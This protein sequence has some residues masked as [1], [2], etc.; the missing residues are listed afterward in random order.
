MLNLFYRNS[1][2]LVL[3]ICL[4]MVA[5]LSSLWVLPRMEDPLSTPRAASVTTIFPGADAERVESLVTE[6]LEEALE[7]IQ[8][9]KEVRSTS[10]AGISFL[11]IELRDDVYEATAPS[12][13]SRIR[14]KLDDAAVLM[15]PGALEPEFDEV[16]VKAYALIVALRW[17]MDSPPS[18][19]ILRRLL[20]Q[21]EDRVSGVAGTEKSELYGD[22]A[23]EIV[24]TLNQQSAV[25]LDLTPEQI[26]RQ[27]QASDAKVSA[28]QMRNDAGDLLLEV[29]GEL[30][31]LTRIGQT[32]IQFGSDGS[33]V[34]LSDIA[35]IEKTIPDPPSSLSLVRNQPAVCLG[36]LVR[37]DARIDSWTHDVM[38]VL[39]QFEAELPTGVK[40]DVIFKQNNYVAQRLSTLMSNLLLG[41]LAV[42]AV[43]F[44][45][46][47]WRSSLIVG[48]ALPLA[49]L[50]V[51]SGLRFL[52]V[53]IHQMSVTG[54]IIALGLLIDNAIVVVDEIA[55]KLKEGYSPA[56]AVTKCVRHLAVPL[57]GSTL[58]TALAFGPI[59]L[60]PGPAGEFVGSI[61]TS[62][63]LAVFSSLL[64]AL[65]VVP[66]FAALGLRVADDQRHA[67]WWREGFSN[68]SL[69]RV[70]TQCLDFVF[71]RPVLGVTLPLV[72]PILGFV[73]A[74]QLPEQFF[75]PADR[76][77]LQVELELPANASIKDTIAV[78]QAIREEALKEES[79]VAM[80][81][82]FGES[83]PVFYYNVIPTRK[84]QPRY[85]QA[86][87]QRN[88]IK[89]GEALI[90]RLQKRL[91]EKFPEVLPLVRQLE[92]G[93]PFYAPIEVRLFGPDVQ[94]LR[95]LGD[96]VRL[97]LTQTPEVLHTRAELAEPLPKVTFAVDEQKARLANLDHV[98][99]ANQ[100][101]RTLEGATGGS[102]L[103]STEELPVRVRVGGG[104]RS[105][106][107][108]I[109][110]L[111][112]LPGG[113]LNAAAGSEDKYQ[114]V[115][116]SAISQMSLDP[117]IAGIPRFNGQ[118][119][120]EIQAFIPAGVL[121]AK[122]LK[123]FQTRL[124]ETDFSLP[125]GYSLAYGGEAAKRDDAIGNL[126]ANV[127]VLMVLM[128][129][130]LV[131][132]FQSFRMASLI[133][134]VAMFSV[135]LGMGSLW[136]YGY[137]FGFMAIIGSMG[138]MGVAIND[139]I[140]V[141]AAILEDEAAKTG[142]RTAIRDVIVKA[143]RHIISTSL[144]TMAGFAPLVYGGGGFWPPLAVAV[145]GGV[146]G[147]TILALV[148][149]PSA[150]RLL[151]RKNKR[152]RNDA[153]S[154]FSPQKMATD[155][156]PLE[157]ESEL[158]AV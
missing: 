66:A 134:V 133:G 95:E 8:E 111:D 82:F 44:F 9:I 62:V 41:S 69:T 46:M 145:S 25:S 18:Y 13:W 3:A 118:R 146:G 155:D 19:G 92:Q 76:D 43:I 112:L 78:A 98:G 71:A 85:A 114:G 58:T 26:S 10:R 65:T 75:P 84:N 153:S 127:G 124:D 106:L 148:F 60:M 30:D 94:R 28:G 49:S 16:D 154:E 113:I 63:I 67:A 100:L 128:I 14:D 105:D 90:R 45:M 97:V 15:P 37:S 35:T 141:L 137:P 57:F 109:A 110:S 140:V 22:P 88:T 51:L 4:I 48:S 32:P 121:P 34:E 12:I 149:V 147:A 77:Q 56:S 42:V 33:F 70:Y 55:Q 52:E 122:V 131:L 144:T 136:L 36:V 11:Q 79:I 93:P 158:A 115:P 72:L 117:E 99:I 91:D 81:W 107:N 87:L 83:A 129:A 53:P 40:L 119:M 74:T 64:L 96:Q 31:T 80:H 38:P 7:E 142:D 50:M 132:S 101:N 150:Y 39:D 108:R 86:L 21:L 130:T 68:A 20:K 156:L 47:G 139:S 6:K 54:L 157:S 59:A 125:P 89:D 120:N 102:V 143:S 27:L 29:S 123:D 135:G 5:G 24:V 73:A 2:L 103:E 61:A 152:H 104:Q 138:L 116:L 151:V 126:L 23:E 17:E 1:R